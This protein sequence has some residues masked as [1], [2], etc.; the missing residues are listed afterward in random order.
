LKKEFLSR[1]EFSLPV[2]K[3]ADKKGGI[4]KSARAADSSISCGKTL[5]SETA[6]AIKLLAHL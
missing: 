6:I 5:E 1:A 4:R 3:A 2:H